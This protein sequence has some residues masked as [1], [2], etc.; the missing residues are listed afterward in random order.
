M[1]SATS[2][3]KLSRSVWTYV[4]FTGL[5]FGAG[6]L[7]VKKLTNDGIDPFTITW[8]PFLISGAL[9]FGT[10]YRRNKLSKAAVLPGVLLGVV[11]GAGPSLIFNY[12]FDELPAGIVTLLISLGPIFTAIV[13]HFVFDDER[14]NSLKGA[15][16]VIAYAGVML[17]TIDSVGEKGS[18]G[19][20]LI[21]LVGSALGG[22][23]AVLT[24]YYSLRHEPMAL[25]A[26]NLF[27][28]GIVALILTYAMDMATQPDGGLAA[29]HFVA[30]FVFGITTF[31]AFLA[32][33]RA[34]QIGTTGQVSVIGYFLP[35][36]GVLG[37]MVF[38]K[39]EASWPLLIG[40]LLIVV[41]MGLIGRGSKGIPRAD[42]Q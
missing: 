9:A 19:D 17:L 12:G 41:S 20:I 31:L 36:F 7:L 25:I 1:L 33:F 3:K 5:T 37:G 4:A 28:A 32:I 34:N 39:E 40:G 27:T 18:L 35:L 2:Y 11:A 16:L 38:F 8:I 42:T 10:G 15:G 26:P 29:W 30:L 21:V 23:A 24:R 22:S 6:A 14:F 13:A